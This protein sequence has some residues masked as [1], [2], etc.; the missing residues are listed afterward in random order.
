MKPNPKALV[1]RGYDEIAEVYL[2]RFSSSVVREAWL[3]ELIAV[4][5]P[6]SEV[7]DLGCGAGVPVAERLASLGHSVTG[8]DSS[9]RQIEIARE[10]VPHATF[11]Q[12]DM[13]TVDL[14]VASF[15]GIAAFYSITH[16]PA[17][18]QGLLLNQIAE[19]LKPAGVFVGSFG[20]G[21]AHAWIGKWLGTDMF[22]SHNSDA[23]TFDL[24]RQAGLQVI[25]AE[26]VQQ[27]NEDARF[28]WIFARKANR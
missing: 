8:V 13:L 16:I 24:V 11:L 9:V 22:F 20:A 4:L 5:P 23:T 27:D 15:D 18:E 21:S 17:T 14:P 26:V 19:W 2:A 1:A 12:S 3:N 25:R 7:L 10:R 6:K 28:L